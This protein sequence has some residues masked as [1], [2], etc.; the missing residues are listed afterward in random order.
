MHM[1]RVKKD[2]LYVVTSPV[3]GLVLVLVPPVILTVTRTDVYFCGQS[4]QQLLQQVASLNP[5]PMVSMS[6]LQLARLLAIPIGPV[7]LLG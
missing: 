4:S 1:K 6:Q 2:L 5:K 3:L 7:V